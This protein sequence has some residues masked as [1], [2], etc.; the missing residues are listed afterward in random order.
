MLILHLP[1]FTVQKEE[2][3]NKNNKSLERYRLTREEIMASMSLIAS[4]DIQTVVI[5]SGEEE[6]LDPEFIITIIKNIKEEIKNKV[7]PYNWITQDQI[8]VFMHNFI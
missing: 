5:Q 3:E 7:S 1:R 6:K 8:K 4:S 2:E